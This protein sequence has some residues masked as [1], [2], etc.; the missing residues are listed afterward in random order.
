MR[1]LIIDDDPINLLFLS[2]AL[3]SHAQ[4]ETA[5]CGADGVEAF[6]RAFQSDQRFDAVLV[7]IRMPGMDGHQTIQK[8]RNIERASGLNG[9]S[10]TAVIMVSAMD[11]AQN[12]NRAFFQGGAISFLS[13]PVDPE[14]LLSELRKFGLLG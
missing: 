10:G 5:S 12:V 7:D 4:T 14:L 8:I 1:V 2:E 3:G 6:E 9:E 11:D 13:K